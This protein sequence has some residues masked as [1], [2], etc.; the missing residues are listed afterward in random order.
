MP[1]LKNPFHEAFCK[2]VAAGISVKTAFSKAY[3]RDQSPDPNAYRLAARNDVKIRIQ[4]IKDAAVYKEVKTVE[5]KRH[6]LALM[7]EGKIPTKVVKKASGIEATFDRLEAIKLDCRI[8][9]E[10]APDKLEVNQAEPLM[11][12]F[13]MYHRNSTNAPND[14]IEAEL[15]HD[16]VLCPKPETIDAVEAAGGFDLS[17]YDEIK[18]PKKHINIDQLADHLKSNEVR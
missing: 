17:E 12:E 7:M 1:K 5:E 18:I 4:E 2:D 6:M 3:P 8:A 14:F 15:I 16:P 11:L 9:G 13:K 10:F